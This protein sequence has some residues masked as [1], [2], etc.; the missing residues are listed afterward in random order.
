MKTLPTL[1]LEVKTFVNYRQIDTETHR[2]LR[3]SALQF[4]SP[5][6]RKHG[7][8]KLTSV[9]IKEL[10]SS[11]VGTKFLFDLSSK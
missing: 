7:T 5:I 8:Q 1:N 3:A 9:G 4:Q 10:F 2:K 6:K 11:P